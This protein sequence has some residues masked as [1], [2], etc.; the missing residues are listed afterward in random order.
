MKFRFLN[1]DIEINKNRI[2]INN[3]KNEDILIGTSINR[4]QLTTKDYKKII[5][6]SFM[7][8]KWLNKK[9]KQNKI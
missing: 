6:F 1:R 7:P 9:F 4:K 2:N 8:Y 3:F 5:L